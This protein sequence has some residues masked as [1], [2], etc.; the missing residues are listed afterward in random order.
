MGLIMAVV[1]TCAFVA[2]FFVIFLDLTVHEVAVERASWLAGAGAA[3]VSVVAGWA[4]GEGVLLVRDASWMRSWTRRV[5]REEA[6]AH[7]TAW[8]L[9][10]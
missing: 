3:L 6:F 10:A 7:A 8:F 5:R 9:D 2:S 1:G 4:A